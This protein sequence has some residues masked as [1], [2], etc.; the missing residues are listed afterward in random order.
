MP[1]IFFCW[2]ALTRI[3]LL[4]LL[5][6]CSLACTQF[7]QAFELLSEFC[8]LLLFRLFIHGFWQ[9]FILF[10]SSSPTR[11]HSETTK[12][13]KLK[14]I[15][16]CV[17]LRLSTF[18]HLILVSRWLQHV[19]VIRFFP[20]ISLC[21]LYLS[22]FLLLYLAIFSLCS[23]S[24]TSHFPMCS[25]LSDLSLNSYLQARPDLF[26]LQTFRCQSLSIWTFFVCRSFEKKFNL[27][28]IHFSTFS[29]F[30]VVRTSIVADKIL[31]ACLPFQTMAESFGIFA[32]F[33]SHRLSYWLEFFDLSLFHSFVDFTCVLIFF[34]FRRP[35]CTFSDS[36]FR[37]SDFFPRASSF[38][39][40]IF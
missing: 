10:R 11:P 27:F 33:H 39:F 21:S 14:T 9:F 30:P 29:T 6:L 8:F 23:S 17:R 37:I 34:P 3:F 28:K 12:S 22:L 18:I 35:F 7:F 1:N 20:Y 36:K 19:R 13:A 16:N 2:S 31:F 4:F 40:L 26:R 24:L 5:L 25:S 32:S 15:L 38:L